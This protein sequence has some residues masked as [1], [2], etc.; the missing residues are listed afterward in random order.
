MPDRVLIRW[1]LLALLVIVFDQITKSIVSSH[2]LLGDSRTVTAFFALVRVHNSGAAF[3]LFAD[4]SG[5]QRG[6][7][8]VVALVASVALTHFL[9]KHAREPWL[10]AALALVLGGALGNLIDRVLL[11]HVVDFLYFHYRGFSWPAFNIADIAIS[12]GAIMLVFDGLL[13]KRAVSST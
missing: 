12:C 9:R 2:F 3:S 4:Q 5:W 7:F 8:I 13:A 10:A 11:G 1:L 6:F